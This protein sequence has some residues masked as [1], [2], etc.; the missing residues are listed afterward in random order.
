MVLNFLN[1]ESCV[2]LYLNEQ[3]TFKEIFNFL[4][5]QDVIPVID[6]NGKV[7]RFVDLNSLQDK[8]S[9]QFLNFGHAPS[10]DKLSYADIYDDFLTIINKI[11]KSKHTTI[12]YLNGD[13][14]MLK[15]VFTKKGPERAIREGISNNLYK[16]LWF[17]D[18]GFIIK[19]SQITLSN[20][21]A[22]EILTNTDI[23]KY[24]DSIINKKLAKGIQT[25]K[26]IYIYF[27][28]DKNGKDIQYLIFINFNENYEIEIII[29][30]AET[31]FSLMGYIENLQQLQKEYNALLECSYDGIYIVDKNGY[32]KNVNLAWERI[33][34]IKREQ[35]LNNSVDEM[36]K[37]GFFKPVTYKSVMEKLSPV[38]IIQ[39]IKDGKKVICTGNPVFDDNGDLYEIIVNVRDIT[40]LNE[41]KREIERYQRIRQRNSNYAFD[42]NDVKDDEIII[43]SPEMRKVLKT[44]LL[45]AKVDSTVLITGESGV[46]KE[47]IAQIIHSKSN[48]KDKPFIEVNCG[49]I[50]ENLLES[51]LFGYEEGSFTGAKKSGKIGLFE[52]ADGGTV[53]L[54]EIADLPLHLQVKLLRVIETGEFIPV[55]SNQKK[56]VNVKIISATN[57]NLKEMVEKKLFREDLFYRLNVITIY[58]PPL[59]QRKE[60]I[61]PLTFFFLEQY[62]ARYGKNKQISPEALEMLIEYQWPGNVREL[63]NLI[64]MLV[65]LSPEDV[66]TPEDLPENIIKEDLGEFVSDDKLLTIKGIMPLSSALEYTESKILEIAYKKYGSIYKVAEALKI[67]KSSAARKINKYKG[68]W[69]I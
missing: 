8:T 68:K 52:Y 30:E 55:G 11:A 16:V 66:I 3:Y 63:R 26:Y 39:Q 53:F 28:T 6:G 41:I 42:K 65:V 61:E 2:K 31:C 9:D 35:V 51:E 45:S 4:K 69:K 10:I 36:A 67:S 1:T 48:R 47:K 32:T 50:P 60:E 22:K 64:E 25:G 56:K 49:A 7:V 58:V 34:G 37:K 62:N 44:A 40:E 12:L 5:I 29:K 19:N 13:D 57:R 21:K 23:Y 15:G 27:S 46:G 20:K 38:T 18:A 43:E 59:R 54:D 17:I 24:I 14:G 33:T